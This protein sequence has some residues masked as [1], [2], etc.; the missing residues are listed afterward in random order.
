MML[1]LL[2]MGLKLLQEKHS[3]AKCAEKITTEELMDCALTT[4]LDCGT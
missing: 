1:C 2:T 4:S 3:L